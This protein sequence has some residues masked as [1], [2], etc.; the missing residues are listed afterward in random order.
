ML[1]KILYFF[2]FLFLGVASGFLTYKVI[3]FN[4]KVAVP[5]LKGQAPEAARGVLRDLGLRLR[6]TGKGFDPIIPP[7]SIIGQVP[8]AGRK[9]RIDSTVKVI[10]SEGPETARMPSVLGLKLEDANALLKREGLGVQETISVQSDTVPAGVVIA[11]APDPNEKTGPVTL[12][13]SGGPPRVS[14]YCPDFRLMSADEARTLGQA[15]GLELVF[16]NA[17]PPSSVVASQKPDPGSEVTEGQ[18]VFLEL[19]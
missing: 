15:L 18:K 1:K 14:Y 11:Q 12:V 13:A 7:G 10:V 17:G 9:L 4:K 5:E 8:E 6:V 3:L 2:L 19:K 16:G